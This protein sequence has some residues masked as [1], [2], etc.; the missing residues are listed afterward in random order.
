M[1]YEEESVELRNTEIVQEIN[2]DIAAR[3]KSLKKDLAVQ[4]DGTVN[5]TILSKFKEILAKT[6]ELSNEVSLRMPDYAVEASLIRSFE[7]FNTP[8]EHVK[9]QYS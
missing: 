8:L 7:I 2:E 3:Y 6:E 4:K 5:E 1:N 9:Q